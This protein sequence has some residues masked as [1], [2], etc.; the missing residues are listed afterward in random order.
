[1]QLT[2]IAPIAAATAV[3][4]FLAAAPAPGDGKDLKGVVRIDGSST[5]YPITE[6][7]AEEF[8]KTAEKVNVTVGVSGTGGGFKRFGAGELDISD[9]SR[10]IKKSEIE[11]AKSKGIEF[12]E[13]PIGF[14][15]LTLVV[16]NQNTWVKQLTIDQVK[17]IFSAATAAKTWKDVDPSWPAE[18][19]KL[20]SPG[21]DSGTFDYFKEVVVGKDGK[22]RSDLSVSEDDNVLVRGVE[23]DKNAMGFFGFA[24]Y[25]ENKEKLNCVAVVNPKTGTAVTPSHETIENASYAPFSRP[26]FLYVNKGSL[27]KP[28]VKAFVDFYLANAPKLVEEVGYVK[29]P[30]AMYD[31]AKANFAAR[32]T[33]T[34]MLDQNGKERP[35]ALADLYK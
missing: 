30:A 15:G 5:V 23:G 13:L 24:Y 32:K 10:P 29:L 7:A 17:A 31:R 21:T 14:D 26:L 19:I 3:L 1:M 4:A 33:G 27:E 8:S 9:A 34:Q 6:A 18:A 35:G 11:A 12:V 20:Y 25:V 2:R 28:Q 22:I 16:N